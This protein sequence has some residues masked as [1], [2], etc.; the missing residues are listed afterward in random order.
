M[1]E[2]S[3]RFVFI[4]IKLKK[5]FMRTQARVNTEGVA[6]ENSKGW[7]RKSKSLW[8]WADKDYSA[9]TLTCLAPAKLA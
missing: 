2:T 9:L 4:F 6:E 3:A 1:K 5:V 7:R 8:V